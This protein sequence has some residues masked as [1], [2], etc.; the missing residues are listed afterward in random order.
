[1]AQYIDL[2]TGDKLILKVPVKGTVNWDEQLK[3][4]NFQKIVDH[5]H[6]GSGNG[7]KITAAA[8]ADNSVITRT[9]AAL[10]VTNEKLADDTIEI[11]KK[12]T[13]VETALTG[14]SATDVANIA[15]AADQAFK[16]NYRI[17]NSGDPTAVQVGT[18]MGQAGDY[19]NDEFIGDD[20][21]SF[22]YDVSTPS[23]PKL[24][25]TG[26]NNDILEFSIEF[27]E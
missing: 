9:I 14:S 13:F 26:A 22:S 11:A 7:S 6:T 8:M 21:A 20:I 15:L 12:K 18:L 4:N 23:V 27:L 10:N 24:Q 19:I 16:I 5:D 2:G 25:I 3:V 1:M 17:H